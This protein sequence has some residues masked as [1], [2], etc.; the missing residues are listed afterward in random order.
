MVDKMGDGENRSQ[1]E[2]ILWTV[3]STSYLHLQSTPKRVTIKSFTESIASMTVCSF[4]RTVIHLRSL[5][6]S[7]TRKW[8]KTSHCNGIS[9]A[10]ELIITFLGMLNQK[11]Q[12]TTKADIILK[13]VM[14]F[15][16]FLVMYSF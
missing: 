15:I 10:D 12:N 11:N 1:Y 3:F 4:C 7:T 8:K 9:V 14:G 13:V 5:S 2:L 6:K 16:D